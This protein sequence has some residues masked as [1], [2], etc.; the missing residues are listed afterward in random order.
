MTTHHLFK[1]LFRFLPS[2]TKWQ[3]SMEQCSGMISTTDCNH[4][5]KHHWY[6]FMETLQL[7]HGM[8][9]TSNIIIMILQTWNNSISPSSMNGMDINESN[10]I[11]WKI[12]TV[13]CCC[14]IPKMISWLDLIVWF[15]VAFCI[16][17]IVSINLPWKSF[18]YPFGPKFFVL[19]KSKSQLL[20]THLSSRQYQV[21]WQWYWKKISHW[22]TMILLQCV[23][24]AT[25]LC[26]HNL[27]SAHWS[28]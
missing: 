26:F 27:D 18:H 1:L 17:Q 23:I 2:V 12:C 7:I 3:T 20:D 11:E 25:I 15:F 6:Y 28:W 16:F 5:I 4:T 14:W 19:P 22:M 10:I 13:S 8:I 24:L 21:I 9:F